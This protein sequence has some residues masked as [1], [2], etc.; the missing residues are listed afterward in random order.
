MRLLALKTQLTPIGRTPDFCGVFLGGALHGSLE[1]LIISHAQGLEASLGLRG[2]APFKCYAVLPPPCCSER[3]LQFGSELAFGIVLYGEAARHAEAVCA[4]LRHWKILR[5][6]AGNASITSI[7]AR[8]HAP[9]DPLAFPELPAIALEWITP[10]RLESRG[11]RKA[12]FAGAPPGLLRVVRS[13][14]QRVRSL[15]PA[16]A[17]TL[18]LHA[19]TW[20]V[21]EEQIRPIA[22]HGT[23]WRTYD[24]R[25][26]SRTKDKPLDFHGELGRVDYRGHIPAPIHALLRWGTWFGAGQRTTLGQG[27]YRIL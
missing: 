8:I 17:K 1:D 26:G 18:G 9:P 5:H 21:A 2:T 11:Q 25:Y 16:L 7:E 15:E 6:P 12:G 3:S 22:G 27:H 24:W 10:L 20:I 14:A 13:L 23:N 19:P 4:A